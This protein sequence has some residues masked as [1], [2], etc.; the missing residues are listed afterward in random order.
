MIRSMKRSEPQ[1]TAPVVNVH[2]AAPPPPVVAGKSELDVTTAPRDYRRELWIG[3]AAAVA[4]SDNCTRPES[5][6]TFADHALAAF[7]A[8]FGEK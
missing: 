6:V 7:D 8:R 5:M 1:R 3:I 4:R 2:V